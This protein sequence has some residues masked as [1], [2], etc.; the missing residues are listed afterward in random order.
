[1][2]KKKQSGNQNQNTQKE[3]TGAL[4][5][6]WFGMWSKFMDQAQF[7]PFS[8]AAN[9]GP[10]WFKGYEEMTRNF[11]QPSLAGPFGDLFQKVMDASGIYMNLFKAWSEVGGDV[12]SSPDA[13]KHLLDLWLESQKTVFSRLFGMPVP[14][15]NMGDWTD[16]ARKSLENFTQFYQQ[17]YQPF[18]DSWGKTFQGAGDAFT[19]KFDP[20]RLRELYDT[21]TKGYESAMGKFLKMPMI[22][23]SRQ[24][25]DKIAR[26]LDAYMKYCTAVTE[27]QMVLYSPGK[28]TVQEL[29]Q[30]ASTILKGEM[31]QE[32]YQ[33]FYETLIKT[34][35]DRFYQL[36]KTPAF[37]Q[38]LKTTLDSYLEFRKQHFAVIEEM[39]KST[40]IITRTE[41]DDVYQELYN[42]KKRIKELE[43]LLKNRKNK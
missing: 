21:W 7:N 36:F 37:G 27:F 40:P 3:S 42:L 5:N 25:L 41:I 32:K 26:S 6:P 31:T 35:E 1:M 11:Y 10:N 4:N 20:A 43:K 24:V 18:M 8:G 29:S 39:L 16:A 28:E 15:A 38:I 22:G 2:P 9:A 13:M 23:P 17:N 19:G 12:K 30:K 34:F 33:E 14:D